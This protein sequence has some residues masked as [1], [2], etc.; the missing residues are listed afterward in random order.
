[1]IVFPTTGINL[2]EKNV[3]LFNLIRAGVGPIEKKENKNTKDL[4]SNVITESLGVLNG[5]IKE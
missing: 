3:F 4:C 5:L 2:T 1:L